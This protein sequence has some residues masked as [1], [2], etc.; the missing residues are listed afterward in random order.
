MIKKDDFIF[1]LDGNAE[2]GNKK[3]INTDYLTYAQNLTSQKYWDRYKLWGEN[4]FK[5]TLGWP[6][7][8]NK[9]KYY[10]YLCLL[11]PY[12]LVEAKRTEILRISNE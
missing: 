2:R 5:D 3:G 7:Y 12:K 10:T 8:I 1:F 6:L 11:R 4:I 9:L